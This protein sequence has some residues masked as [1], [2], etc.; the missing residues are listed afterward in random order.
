[1]LV[2]VMYVTLWLKERLGVL[3]ND[4]LKV[5]PKYSAIRRNT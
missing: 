5:V 2:E 1:M 3:S 4:S